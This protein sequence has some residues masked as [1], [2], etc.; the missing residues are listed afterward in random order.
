LAFDCEDINLADQKL[1]EAE[2]LPLLHALSRG[3]FPRLK[4]LNLVR[5]AFALWPPIDLTR[6]VQRENDIG[7]RGAELIAEGLKANSSVQELRLVMLPL[8]PPHIATR[9]VVVAAA[10]RAYICDAGQ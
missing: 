6:M 10:S 3:E 2:L 8:F 4:R 7:D 1:G 9:V 5:A